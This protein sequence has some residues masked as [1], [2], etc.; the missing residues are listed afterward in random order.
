MSDVASLLTEAVAW[1]R[2]GRKVALATVV[3]TWGSSPR[4]VG[5]RLIIDENGD[6]L[7]SVSGGC[8]EGAVIE[9]AFDVI[10]AGKAA[11]LD[12]GVSDERAWTVGLSCGGKISIFVERFD[13]FEAMEQALADLRGGRDVSLATRLSDGARFRLDGAGLDGASAALLREVAH[14]KANRRVETPEGAFFVETWRPDLR[15]ILIGAV[16]IS[17]ALAPIA[18]ACGYRTTIIDPRSAFATPERFPGVELLARWPDEV[19][20]DMGLD[21]GCAIV[22]LTHDPKIDD[23]ALAIALRSKAFYIGA[24]GSR[25]T[26]GRRFERL[27]EKGF[28]DSDLARIHG[29]VGVDI[30][31]ISPAEIALSVMAEITKCLRQP[32][33]T[34]EAAL[35]AV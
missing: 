4:P 32:A 14:E 27:R 26:A 1:R 12:F 7:G 2:L 11:V 8:V 5:S 29:P 13:D 33:P 22:A 17:Q 34:P 6:F 30:G 25:K 24:L 23:R 9:A 10:E 20:Q 21:A 16:H 3:G 19:M 15:L 35:H 28:A 31:A 18:A